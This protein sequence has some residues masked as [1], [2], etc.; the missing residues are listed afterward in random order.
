[1]T[2][3]HFINHCFPCPDIL[4]VFFFIILPFP[5]LVNTRFCEIFITHV[6]VAP[7]AL[8]LWRVCA[9]FLRICGGSGPPW[10]HPMAAV[11]AAAHFGKRG[12]H[13]KNLC[14]F[15]ANSIKQ[16]TGFP[17]KADAHGE[18]RA[19][20]FLSSSLSPATAEAAECRSGGQLPRYIYLLPRYRGRQ[21]TGFRRTTGEGAY[22]R[23]RSTV[24][25]GGVCDR[26]RSPYQPRYMPSHHWGRHIDRARSPHNPVICLPLGWEAA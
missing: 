26:A 20:N 12:I 10:G 9:I 6:S 17:H 23:R 7:A 8:P 4:R 16:Q 11:S 5:R 2:L 21:R 22:L 24:V 19:N 13:C 15:A 18:P 14:A 3:C 1:M 25:Q